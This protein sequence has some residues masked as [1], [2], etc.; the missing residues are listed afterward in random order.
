MEMTKL[1]QYEIKIIVNEAEKPRIA[2]AVLEALPEWFG[3]P[4]ARESYIKNSADK[5]FIAA[6]DGEK[7]VGFLYLAETGKATAELHCMGVLKEYH[8]N[9]VGR[10]IVEKAKRL[11]KCTGY[12]FLQVKTVKRGVYEEYDKTNDFYIACGFKEFEIIPELWGEN[13]PCQIYILALD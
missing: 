3:I 10:A 1:M 12:S 7:P 11:A 8:R 6:F 13:N 4:E 5:P 2:R 9:G